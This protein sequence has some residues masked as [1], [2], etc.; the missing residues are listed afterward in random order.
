MVGENIGHKKVHCE[1]QL[2]NL[3]FN[4]IKMWPH[5]LVFSLLRQQMVRPL[6]PNFWTDL[7][8]RVVC[9]LQV[10][11][12]VKRRQNDRRHLLSNSKNVGY[13]I[14]WKKKMFN[15]FGSSRFCDYVLIS[16]SVNLK[17]LPK[18]EQ[19]ILPY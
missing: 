19:K 11:Q 12:I 16:R 2:L 18:K 8:Q 7:K 14:I 3:K 4:F 1:P 10:K 13:F 6:R 17:I 15:Y 9:I 5:C